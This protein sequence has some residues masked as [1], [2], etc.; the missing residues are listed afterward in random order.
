MPTSRTKYLPAKLKLNVKRS[1][2]GLGLF[3]GETIPKG[4]CIIEYVGTIVPKDKVETTYTRY[5]FEVNRNKTIDGSLRSNTARYINHSCKPNAEV[6][7]HNARVF[8]MAL[9]AIPA[10]T[11]ITYDYGEE[12][13]DEYIKPYGC[14]CGNH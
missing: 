6:E 3:A 4:T 9:S 11:E 5:L 10:G 7:I 8:I 13:V 14:K 1:K 12:Y 2:S